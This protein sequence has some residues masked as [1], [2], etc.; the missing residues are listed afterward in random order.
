MLGLFAGT[1]VST[2]GALLQMVNHG[3]STGALFLL[4]GV[5]YDRRH[6]RLIEDFGGLAK[7][8]PCLHRGVP[9]R[10]PGSIGLP[11]STASSASS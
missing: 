8:M 10:H 3:L 2:Q 7:V 5:I 6:T 9:P 4:V 1:V 11:G